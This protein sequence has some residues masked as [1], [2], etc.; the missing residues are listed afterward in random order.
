MWN[1]ATLMIAAMVLFA[2]MPVVASELDYSGKSDIADN[3]FLAYGYNP[4]TG[5]IAGYLVALRTAPGR[6]DECKLVFGGYP[7]RLLVKYLEHEWVRG[8]EDRLNAN[9]YIKIGGDKPYLSFRKESL[10]GDCDWIL[11]FVVQTNLS[12]GS[13]EITVDMQVPKIGDWTSVYLIGAR[14]ARFYSHPNSSSGRKAFLVKGDVIY[15]YDERPGWFYAK[16]EEGKTKAEGWIRKADTL[17][18]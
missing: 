8:A 2:G 7:N 3:P 17:Q 13:K 5:I 10:G 16:Y 4:K 9:V 1:I 6:T 18:P 15:V 11:P 14:K 12:E